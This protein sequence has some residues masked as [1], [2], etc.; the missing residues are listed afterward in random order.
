MR[1]R[2]ILILA[3]LIISVF[4]SFTVHIPIQP[5]DHANDFLS[6]DVC[7]VSDSFMSVNSD[8]PT[9]HECASNPLPLWFTELIRNNNLS[10]TSQQFARQIEQPPRIS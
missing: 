2:A 3:A 10:F 4:S 5:K 8:A 7:H 9:L 6:I 1:L